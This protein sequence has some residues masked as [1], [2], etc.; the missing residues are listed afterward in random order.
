M[1]ILCITYNFELI[2]VTAYF[3]VVTKQTLSTS[4]KNLSQ[5]VIISTQLQFSSQ[6]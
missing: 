3:Y 6:R 1:G 5:F 4:E 2:Y